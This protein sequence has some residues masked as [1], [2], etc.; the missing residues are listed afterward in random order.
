MQFKAIY[1][2]A[3]HPILSI[4]LF[5]PKTEKGR[6]HLEKELAQLMQH[7]VGFVSVTY[8]AG[9]STQNNTLDLVKRIRAQYGVTT[10]PHFTCVGASR[11][12]I[13]AYANR[14]IAE[15]AENMVALRGDPPRGQTTFV[16]APDGFR[17][18]YQLVVFLKE[19]FG[20]RLSLAVAGY[21]EGHVE[22]RDLATS[23]EHLKI[24]V[25]AGADLVITQLFYD[26][27]DFFRFRDMAVKAGINVPIVPGLLPITKYSQID[28][29]TKLCG[30]SIPADLTKLLLSFEDGSPDQQM[31]GIAAAI[32]QAGELLENDVPGIHIFTLNNSFATA[33]MVEALGHYFE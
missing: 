21:P 2:T 33:H 10:V 20:D 14:A 11:Q 4:E 17:Y 29:I 28:R 3:Q 19:R 9:G 31:A 22:T 26:N 1:R 13:L 24:K 7:Q 23:I 8:G 18:A 32:D 30:A 12:S 16:P 6:A 15:G 5:P 25:D 27:A